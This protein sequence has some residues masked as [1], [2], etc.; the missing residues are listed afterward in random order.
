MVRGAV[1]L[2]G[3]SGIGLA[4]AK[5]A[6]HHGADTQREKIRLTRQD[7]EQ[8]DVSGGAPKSRKTE[9]RDFDVR[10]YRNASLRGDRLGRG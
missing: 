4:T 10:L 6:A 1:I 3:T 2:G 7:G 8:D 9:G 5:A